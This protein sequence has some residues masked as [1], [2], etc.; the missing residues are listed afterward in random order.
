MLCSAV[1][2]RE[3]CACAVPLLQHGACLVQAAGLAKEVVDVRLLAHH[4]MVSDPDADCSRVRHP[5]CI[6]FLLALSFCTTMAFVRP[7]R[8]TVVVPKLAA[9]LCT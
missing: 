2:R 8:L 3:C 9:E 5:A 7:Q 1:D 6:M 4:D